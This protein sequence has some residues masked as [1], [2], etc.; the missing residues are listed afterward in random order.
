MISLS[1]ISD[2]GEIDLPGDATHGFVFQPGPKGLGVPTDVFEWQ[3]SP[4]QGARVRSRRVAMREAQWPIVILGD[5]T[6][7][8][9]GMQRQLA[10][11]T[12]PAANPAMVARYASG[13]VFR[14][15]FVVVGGLEDTVEYEGATDL[16]LELLVRCPN[17][18]WVSEAP[19]QVGPV[20]TAAED[21]GLLPDLAELPVGSSSA[22]GDLTVEN[23]G[24][25]ESPVSWVLRGPGGPISVELGGRGF[26]FEDALAAGE[27]VTITRTP[28]GWSVT[29][30]TGA[31]RYAS[32]GPAPKFP[33]IPV[34]VSTG[35][36]Q[37]VDA[38]SG[39]M[40]A[41]YFYVLKKTVI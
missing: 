39:A 1:I 20:Q 17:P 31:N 27:T 4:V 37:M 13:E 12:S 8:V 16:E 25:V 26:V 15:P 30:E 24:D 22:F 41:G 34:G 32:L 5:D 40:V 23:A 7:D 9:R 19:Q 36:V 28:R 10:N 6:D 2:R 29:D 14:L 3:E 38:A 11:I 33:S 35:T 21:V 18:F